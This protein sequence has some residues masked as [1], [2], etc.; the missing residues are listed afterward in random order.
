VP[1]YQSGL[2]GCLS[3]TSV[4][5]PDV[6][7]DAAPLFHLLAQEG[8]GSVLATPL[9]AEN[10]IFGILVVG[11]RSVDG[12]SAAEAE[13]LRGL[14][15]H[16]SLAAHHARLHA[17][18]QSAYDK[19]RQSQ[20]AIMQQERLAAVGQLSAGVAHDFNNILCVIQGYASMLLDV[21]D[22]GPKKVEALK[23]ISTAAQ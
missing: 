8:V 2:Q 9:S 10:R 11:R 23:Q 1:I 12:F 20:E 6:T 7:R 5:Q 4:Y 17:D 22:R 3:G 15:E 18:L 21:E 19:L 13:F 16:I 14:S